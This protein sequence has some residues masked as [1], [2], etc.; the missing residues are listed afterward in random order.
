MEEYTQFTMRIDNNV[1]KH[2][3]ESAAKNKRS[4]AKEIEYI[5]EQWC[6]PPKNIT[7]SENMSAAVQNL[8]DVLK[9]EG[10]I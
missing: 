3:K 5:L 1:Y 10:A 6:N 9:K 8:V 2:V 4:I 7:V